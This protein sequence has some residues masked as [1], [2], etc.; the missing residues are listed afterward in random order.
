ML[1]LLIDT[2]AW[3]DMATR[4]DGQKW[5][6]PLRVLKFQGKLELLVPAL[7]IEEFNRNRPRSESAVTTSVLD[8]LRQL[9]REL[10]EYAGDKHEHVWLAETAQHIPLVNAT[11]PQNFR[12]IDELLRGGTILE[13]AEPEYTRAIQRGLDKRAPFTSD[14]NSVADA[15]LIEIYASQIAGASASDVYAFV[16]SNYRDFS[17]P[18][19]DRRQPHPDLAG[20]FDGTGSRYA[21]QVEGLH[22]VLLEQFGDEYL[23]EQDEVEFLISEEEPRT[24]AEIIEAEK[25]FFDKVWYVRSIVHDDDEPETPEDIRTGMMAARQRVE[26][27]YGHAELWEAIGPGHDEAWQYGYISGKL[28]T[29][30]WVLGSEWDFLDT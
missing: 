3:L 19:G 29:L 6:V 26:A 1:R 9:R 30:R 20:L 21:Y 28:A 10:R 12:E 15:L 25:E 23:Q 17:V 16:T 2:S 8:R 4:R 7:I 11:A 24:L 22:Q 5:I 14:K 27:E 18:N 13:P